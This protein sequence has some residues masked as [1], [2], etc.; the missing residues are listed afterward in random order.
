MDR[1]FD[2]TD[3][4]RA[5]IAART[6]KLPTRL[7]SLLLLIDGKHSAGEVIKQVGVLGLNEQS[8][9]ELLDGDFIECVTDTVFAKA[10]GTNP[11][12]GG[13]SA[14]IDASAAQPA[15][16]STVNIPASGEAHYQ[17]I[18]N[19]Y[20]QN[21]GKMLG[22]RGFALQ[23]KVERA[24]T[25]EQLRALRPLYLEAIYIAK[26]AETARQLR[27]Q[28]DQLLY[29]G[30]S[31]KNRGNRHRIDATLQPVPTSTAVVS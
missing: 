21:I 30:S 23:L 12:Y 14:T 15:Q 25:L 31:R 27:D 11:G 24:K 1:I 18:Y 26:G 16:F 9:I 19:C 17:A 3:K 2:K 4:G 6:H 8:I 10:S 5:E 13:T 7:R 22:L 29:W 20:T 28:L